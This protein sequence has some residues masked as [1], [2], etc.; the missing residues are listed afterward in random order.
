MG[1]YLITYLQ[2]HCGWEPA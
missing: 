1:A 2:N